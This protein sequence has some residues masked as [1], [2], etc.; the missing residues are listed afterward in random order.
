MTFPINYQAS[1]AIALTFLNSWKN[2]NPQWLAKDVVVVFYSDAREDGTRSKPKIG[3]NYSQAI[4][5]FLKWYYVG[6]DGNSEDVKGI[7]NPENKIHGRC[8]MLRQGFPFIFKNYQFERFA[9]HVEGINSKLSDID[10]LDGL[11]NALGREGYG[12]DW[13]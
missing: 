3:Q 4:S 7:L 2:V 8:G 13:F 5:E 12:H 9:L 1:V 6:F 11:R 10:Y